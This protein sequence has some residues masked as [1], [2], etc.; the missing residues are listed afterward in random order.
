MVRLYNIV[1]SETAA[2]VTLCLTGGVK[3]TNLLARN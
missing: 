2:T 1:A 3:K